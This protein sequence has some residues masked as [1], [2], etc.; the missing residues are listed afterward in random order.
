LLLLPFFKPQKSND[1][2]KKYHLSFKII[3]QQ[4]ASA[5]LDL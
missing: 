2:S 4:Q 1:S 5:F 3:P